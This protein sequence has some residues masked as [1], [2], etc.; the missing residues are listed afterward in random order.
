[1][2]DKKDETLRFKVKTRIGPGILNVAGLSRLALPA[3]PN[4]FSM[5]CRVTEPLPCVLCEEA[6][7]HRHEGDTVVI[8]TGRTVGK[9]TKLAR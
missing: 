3:E 1:M 5:G 2:T 7:Q 6:K 4:A 9:S 8:K